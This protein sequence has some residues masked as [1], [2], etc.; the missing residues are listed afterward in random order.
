MFSKYTN[1]ENAIFVHSHFRGK[2]ASVLHFTN[3]EANRK[4]IKEEELH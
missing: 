1:K 4:F 3:W 2:V